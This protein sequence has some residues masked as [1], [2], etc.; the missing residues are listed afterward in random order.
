M[1]HC[2]HPGYCVIWWLL[3]VGSCLLRVATCCVLLLL[4]CCLLRVVCCVLLVCS[5]W[6][7]VVFGVCLFVLVVAVLAFLAVVD[8]A[9]GDCASD[10]RKNTDKLHAET[11][12]KVTSFPGPWWNTNHNKQEIWQWPCGQGHY[13][14]VEVIINAHC[15]HVPWLQLHHPG[16][17]SSE[18]RAAMG[19]LFSDP[20]FAPDTQVGYL[21]GH[22][23]WQSPVRLP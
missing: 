18:L 9:G 10:P 4:V 8:L 14:F 5:A 23:D 11:W 22:V 16:W 7:L 3:L 15:S 6:C 1:V 2:H 19:R 13:Q 21:E 12:Q 17:I 20:R